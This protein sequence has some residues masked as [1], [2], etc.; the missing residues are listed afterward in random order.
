[1]IPVMPQFI[2]TTTIYHNLSKICPWGERKRGKND[3]DSGGDSNL[4]P[5]KR[6][7]MATELLGNSVAEFEYLR[8]SFPGSSQKYAHWHQQFLLL[9]LLWFS[10]NGVTWIT[11]T[12]VW[13]FLCRFP[14]PPQ[15]IIYDSGWKLH[16]YVLNHEPVHFKNTIFLVDV[17]WIAKQE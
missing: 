3:C 7:A 5:G 4:W 1:M 6:P 14:T 16:Q 9:E 10:G 8:L 15:T 12:F 2:T 11:S 17:H 13:N